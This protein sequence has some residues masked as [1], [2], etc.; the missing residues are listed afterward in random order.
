MRG[1]RAIDDRPLAILVASAEEEH[2]ASDVS[3]G[4]QHRL[5][6]RQQPPL[7]QR[8]EHTPH[9]PCLRGARRLDCL[10]PCRQDAPQIIVPVGM[11][12][13]GQIG[14]P[15]LSA[16]QQGRNRE[17]ILGAR[18]ISAFVHHGRFC[19]RA[20][21]VRLHHWIDQINTLP[22]LALREA[23]PGLVLNDPGGLG[24]GIR[25]L[26]NQVTASIGFADSLGHL[27]HDSD[28]GRI[29][30]VA[31]NRPHDV[32]QVLVPR[33]DESSHRPSR[34][35]PTCTATA[36]CAAGRSGLSAPAASHR[37]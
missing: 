27:P 7:R 37:R 17:A 34:G 36:S 23:E 13:T 33:R 26:R 15:G 18:L 22:R 4:G 28:Q 8:F 9:L 10:P 21:V 16:Y 14:I 29:I 5:V 30:H 6:R 24:R 25:L 20:S 1:R 2:V 12:S 11:E 35:R 31:V 32:R 3:P 19:R